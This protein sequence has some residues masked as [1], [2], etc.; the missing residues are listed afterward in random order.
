MIAGMIDLFTFH[1]KH[2]VDVH[3]VDLD[4]VFADVDSDARDN[5]N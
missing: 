2:V 4:G 5:Q 3:D 1:F